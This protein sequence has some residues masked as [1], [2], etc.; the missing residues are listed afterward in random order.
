MR[1]ALDDPPYY[2]VASVEVPNCRNGY[3]RIVTQTVDPQRQQ[4]EQV[5]LRDTAGSWV[6]L[7][8]GSGI[9]CSDAEVQAACAALG[10]SQ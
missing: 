8:H 10:L 9:A 6:I 4:A 2:Q 1:A 7:T 3:A 5:F